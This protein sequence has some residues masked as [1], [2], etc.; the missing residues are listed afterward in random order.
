V[1]AGQHATPEDLLLESSCLGQVLILLA[2]APSVLC[3]CTREIDLAIRI[4]DLNLI[5]ESSGGSAKPDLQ[6]TNLLA[7]SGLEF[8]NIRTD[9]LDESFV[10]SLLLSHCAAHPGGLR[11]LRCRFN[12]QLGHVLTPYRSKPFIGL[13]V[14]STTETEVS[15]FNVQGV[16]TFTRGKKGVRKAGA[17]DSLVRFANLATG[18]QQ[19]FWAPI[20]RE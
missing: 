1:L 18:G 17:L 5:T 8:A 7:I 16:S 14:A 2:R 10:Q 15:G 6:G 13:Y 12:C 19:K 20:S 9:L 4:P 3:S 11:N